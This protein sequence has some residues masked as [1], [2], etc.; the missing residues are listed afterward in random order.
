[1]VDKSQ[2]PG[3]CAKKHHPIMMI[4]TSRIRR[5]SRIWWI[6]ARTRTTHFMLC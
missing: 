2:T 6:R 4:S 3:R 5:R 1:M